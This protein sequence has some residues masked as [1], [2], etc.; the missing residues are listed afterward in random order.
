MGVYGS[1]EGRTFFL[2]GVE[3]AALDRCFVGCREKLWNKSGEAGGGRGR[4]GRAKEGDWF[5]R[6]LA[7]SWRLLGCRQR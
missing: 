7:A 4:R 5:S 2:F 3:K 6:N 1:L